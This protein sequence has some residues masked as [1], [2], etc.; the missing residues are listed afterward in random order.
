VNLFVKCES[1]N[2]LS[3]VKERLAIAVIDEELAISRSTPGSQLK[4]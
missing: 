1:F 4:P 3:S 2:P